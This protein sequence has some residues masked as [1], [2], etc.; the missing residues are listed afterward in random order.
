[1]TPIFSV[2]LLIFNATAQDWKGFKKVEGN[3]E[4]PHYEAVVS[5]VFK[6]TVFNATAESHFEIVDVQKQKQITDKKVLD[7]DPRALQIETCRRYQLSQCPVSKRSGTSTV[8]LSGGTKIHGCRHSFHNWLAM[9]TKLNGLPISEIR[10]PILLRN[11]KDEVVYNSAY[12]PASY[13]TGFVNT[14]DRLN[15]VYDGTT[16]EKTHPRFAAFKSVTDYMTILFSEPIADSATFET[17][18]PQ[19]EPIY[20]YGYPQKTKYFGGTKKGDAPGDTLVASS[21]LVSEISAVQKLVSTNAVTGPGNSGSPVLNKNGQ[22]VSL[23]CGGDKTGSD[24]VILDESLLKSFW[25]QIE[26]VPL[27]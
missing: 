5:S 9:A 16:I 21:G 14:S 18:Q 26:S 8:V 3:E 4:L 15:I 1:M 12:S 2:L 25:K 24:G 23:A 10:V 7:T 19:L 27:D 6:Y 17:A 20:I 11:Y 13:T 22:L